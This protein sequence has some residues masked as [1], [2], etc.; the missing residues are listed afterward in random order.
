MMKKEGILCR[1]S[2]CLMDVEAKD[3]YTRT[4][5]FHE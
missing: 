4:K 3:Y 2:N 5:E 1:K